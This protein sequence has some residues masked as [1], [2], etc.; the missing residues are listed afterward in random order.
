MSSDP[1]GREQERAGTDAEDVL[2]RRIAAGL[3]DVGLLLVLFFVL[4]ITIGDT[5]SHSASGS[6]SR[7]VSL[8]GGAFLLYLGLVLAYYLVFEALAAATP[9]K[10]L[11]GLRVVG[12]DGARPSVGAI[13]LRTLLRIVDWLPFFYLVG[14]I[15][16]LATGSRRRRLGDLAA[17]TSV[18]RA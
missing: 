11:L 13:V 7:T 2:G 6:S 10:L 12:S 1:A 15:A 16:I 3:I 4:A 8:T 9:G 17:K 18:A 5:E 14:F